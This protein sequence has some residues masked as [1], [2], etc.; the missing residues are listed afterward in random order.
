MDPYPDMI[1]ARYAHV[2]IMHEKSLYV[3]GG[4]QY[5]SDENGLLS[6][7]ERFDFSSRKWKSVAS[8]QYPRAAGAVVTF[9]SHIYVFG[10][11]SGDN[12]R[13]RVIE[14]YSEGDSSWKK[15]P[16]LLHAGFEGALVL[17]KPGS[18]SSVLIFGGKT[19]M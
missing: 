17:K 14:S 8:L 10:G 1:N 19:N 13:T 7:C 15:L 2:S 11:Y 9:G 3:L 18:E 5:G 12:N 4:R 6:A 16:Y